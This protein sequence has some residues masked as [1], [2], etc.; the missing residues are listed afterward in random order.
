MKVCYRSLHSWQRAGC[1]GR[2]GSIDT[3]RFALLTMTAGPVTAAHVPASR[4]SAEKQTLSVF[5]RAG[6]RGSRPPTAWSPVAPGVGMG[7]GAHGTGSVGEGIPTHS[8]SRMAGGLKIIYLN[9]CSMMGVFQNLMPEE[10]GEINS[11]SRSWNFKGHRQ[12][13]ATPC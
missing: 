11:I 5:I 10:E 9:I 13:K 8:I 6:G 2:S 7:C 12:S 4:G 3:Q 1:R